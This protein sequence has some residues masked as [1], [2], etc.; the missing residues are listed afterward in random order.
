MVW[1]KLWHVEKVSIAVAAEYKLQMTENGYSPNP[2][3]VRAY[4]SNN[5]ADH[6]VA[7]SSIRIELPEG[8]KL[9]ERM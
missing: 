3:E 5:Q 4:V 7:E 1:K 2:F 9:I 6:S 8:L